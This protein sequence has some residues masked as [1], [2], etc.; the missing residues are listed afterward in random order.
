MARQMASEGA[1]IACTL[2]PSD[3]NA[4]IEEWREL[5]RDALIEETRDGAVSTTLWERRAGVLERLEQLV[6]AERDCCSFLDFHLEQ[7][8]SIVRLQTTFPPGGEAVLDLVF[9]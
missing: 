2:E 4:R 9:G 5:R 7:E 1:P 3:Q 6:E 8:D